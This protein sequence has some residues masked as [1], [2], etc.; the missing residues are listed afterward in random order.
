MNG[1]V[2]RRCE[3]VNVLL[4]VLGEVNRKTTSVDEGHAAR[5]LLNFSSSV[6]ILLVGVCLSFQLHEF[7]V[8]EALSKRPLNNFAIS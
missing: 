6:D 3:V 8:L 4:A 2:L 1:A 7:S 5:F